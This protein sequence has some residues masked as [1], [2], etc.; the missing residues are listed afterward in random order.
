MKVI[1][2]VILLYIIWAPFRR[3]GWAVLAGFLCSLSIECIQFFTRLGKFETDDIMNNV[4][5]VVIGF[6]GCK[7]IDRIIRWTIKRQ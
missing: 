4:I 5:G 2:F 6:L 7:V 3:L 1:P